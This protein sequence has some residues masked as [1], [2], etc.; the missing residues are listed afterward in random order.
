L[1]AAIA[2]AHLKG[3]SFDV[4]FTY[5]VRSMLSTQRL[6]LRMLG[7]KCDSSDASSPL[8]GVLIDVSDRRELAT[9]RRELT[10]ILE[11]VTQLIA[12]PSHD[13][14]HKLRSLLNDL[15]G[16]VE[17]AGVLLSPGP[18]TLEDLGIAPLQAGMI[19]AHGGQELIDQFLGDMDDEAVGGEA[20]SL[21]EAGNKSILRCLVPRATGQRQRV[22]LL[23]PGRVPADEV[24][25]AVLLAMLRGIG[26]ILDAVEYRSQVDASHQKLETQ[27]RH[28]SELMAGLSHDIGSPLSGVN[29]VLEAL[30]NE[31][32]GPLMPLQR[33]LITSSLQTGRH[34]TALIGDL[35]DAARIESGQLALNIRRCSLVEIAQDAIDIVRPQSDAKRHVLSLKQFGNCLADVDQLRCRQMLV[36]LITNA[37]KFSPEG[38]QIWVSVRTR[39]GGGTS[40]SVCD[41]GIGMKRAARAD[42]LRPFVRDETAKTVPGW[43][44]GLSMVDMLAS[45]QG[46]NIR[47]H[48][49]PGRG[50]R[51]SVDFPALVERRKPRDRRTP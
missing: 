10:S 35:L 6:Q 29:N 33:R 8:F 48:S 28:K 13:D 37:V 31:Q 36:N 12:S 3:E 9:R 2:N 30:A 51:F 25:D 18:C 4:E 1:S 49:R 46:A 22:V 44:L 40:T 27:L 47:I 24:D 23:S 38:S 45:L 39:P 15:V 32:F 43:G 14:A 34:V 41:L 5:Y 50:S 11:S 7:S 42:L 16:T 19:A 26:S 21:L 17:G 20:F